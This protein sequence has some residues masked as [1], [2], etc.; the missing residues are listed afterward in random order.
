ME[1]RLNDM[2]AVHFYAVVLAMML[3]QGERFEID[4]LDERGQLSCHQHG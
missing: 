1:Q 4:C 2:S 3:V